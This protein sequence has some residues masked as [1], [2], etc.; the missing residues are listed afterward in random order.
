MMSVSFT[1]RVG[2][3]GA[4]VLFFPLTLYGQSSPV[5]DYG[6]HTRDELFR[7]R[8]GEAREQ[9]EESP[10][11]NGGGLEKKARSILNHIFK[12]EE[13]NKKKPFYKSIE[14]WA[15]QAGMNVNSA[16]AIESKRKKAFR[17]C[18]ECRDNVKIPNFPVG[19]WERYVVNFSIDTGINLSS[20]WLRNRKSRFLRIM[21]RVLP[22]T[23]IAQT[24][25]EA[26]MN[27]RISDGYEREM[28]RQMALYGQQNQ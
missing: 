15:W 7:Y 3:L 2:F 13:E 21:G 26:Y 10:Q 23:R 27:N 20:N 5:I 24:G 28:A 8:Q 14:F 16:R 4:A 19:R 9:T 18:E 11:S 25:T 6:S 1:K 22:S 17:E 12:K